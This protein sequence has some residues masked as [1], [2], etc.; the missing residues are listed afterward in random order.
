MSDRYLSAFKAAEFLAVEK[1]VLDRLRMRGLLLAKKSV[2]GHW[3]YSASDLERVKL[4]IS[5]ARP[6]S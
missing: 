3:L 1:A 2:G 5:E 4:G 6:E